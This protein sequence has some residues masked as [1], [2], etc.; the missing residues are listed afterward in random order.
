MGSEWNAGNLEELHA[1]GI[2]HILNVTRE[3]DN[4]F[5]ADFKYKNIRVYDE[6]STNLRKYFDDSYRY[7]IVVCRCRIKK[8]VTI[9]VLVVIS[10]TS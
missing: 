7:F 4:F 1:N 5:P 2:T 10:L 8:T 3:I 9:T 6:E